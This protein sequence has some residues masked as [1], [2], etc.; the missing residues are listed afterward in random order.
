MNMRL[1]QWMYNGFDFH[2]RDVGSE[3]TRSNVVI[4]FAIELGAPTSGVN[5]GNCNRAHSLEPN[6]SRN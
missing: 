6:K 5:T 3:A 1:V 2:Y 4:P